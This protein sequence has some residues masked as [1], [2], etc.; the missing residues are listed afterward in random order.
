MKLR[1]KWE[2]CKTEKEAK[3]RKAEIEVDQKKGV[4]I[5]PTNE[6]VAEF[7]EDFVR[8][9][10]EKKWGVS[11]YGSSCALIENYVNPLIGHMKVQEITPRFVDR[12]IRQLKKTPSVAAKYRSIPEKNLTDSNIEKIIKLLRCAFKQAVRW[13]M[14]SKNPFDNAILT[15]TPYKKREIWNVETIRRALDACKDGLLYVSMNLS[16]A[17]SMRL[18]EV[19]GLTWDNVHIT[20][21]DISR[22]DAWVYVDKELARVTK[23]AMDMLGDKDIYYVFDSVMKKETST[24]LVLKKPKTDSSVRKIW[25]PKTVAYIL[26]EWRE[27]QLK[28]KEFLGSEYE[29]F[30]LVVALPNGRPCEDRLIEKRFAQL[31]EK[32]KLPDVVFHSLRHSSTTYKLKLNHGDLKA[33]QGDTGHAEID[34][35]TKVYAHILDEDRKLG[36]QKFEDAFYANPDL[37]GV[38]A[39]PTPQIDL[40]ALIA[41]L[42]QS[43]ELAQTL[44]NLIA[45]GNQNAG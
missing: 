10:G 6:T 28:M 22:D 43:P 24:K 19:L 44:S 15:K 13:E 31:K 34:M 20:D 21:D 30:D 27:A 36:A 9:Y 25:L 26:R 4:F 14:I 8:L 42:Q 33:T 17:C 41:Q 29:D 12:Y 38:K 39:P 5:A 16:F 11:M 35:I 1:Q 40:N 37:R 18:G 32:E 2:T 3:L 45:A 7:L 23:R